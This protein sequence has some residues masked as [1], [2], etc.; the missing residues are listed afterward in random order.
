MTEDRNEILNKLKQVDYLASQ[1]TKLEKELVTIKPNL[2]HRPSE[3]TK[4]SAPNPKITK[5]KELI[6]LRKD[7][8]FK[9]FI[10]WTIEIIV[11]I[12]CVFLFL[13][14]GKSD[15]FGSTILLMVAAP[16][17]LIVMIVIGIKIKK[18]KGIS[19]YFSAIKENENR[20]IYNKRIAKENKK[21]IE[22]ENNRYENDLKDYEEKMSLYQ[23]AL[24]EYEQEKAKQINLFEQEKKAKEESINSIGKEIAT[25]LTELS[26]SEEFN[27]NELPL[28][29]IPRLIPYIEDGKAN[30]VEEAINLLCEHLLLVQKEAEEQRQKQEEEEKISNFLQHLFQELNQRD[31]DDYEETESYNLATR[32]TRR[33]AQ[34]SEDALL[35][36]TRR[37]N[38]EMERMEKEAKERREREEREQKRKATQAASQCRTCKYFDSCAR[39]G[40]PDC[41]VYRHY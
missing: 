32:R 34:A 25:L 38:R 16:I 24:E 22:D 12:V 17:C 21:A 36:E 40:T 39:K 27:L 23:K 14:G 35:E 1:K 8:F 4:P 26:P 20:E 31:D 30:T 5:E 41:A 3:P 37:H 29:S 9:S 15:S 13:G 28:N 10:L 6:P 33:R 7:L 19:R 2:P 18:T 11:A